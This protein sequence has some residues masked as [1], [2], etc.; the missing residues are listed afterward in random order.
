MRIRSVRLNLEKKRRILWTTTQLGGNSTLMYGICNGE[1][2]ARRYYQRGSAKAGTHPFLRRSLR[3]ERLGHA[4]VPVRV[5]EQQQQLPL[6][7]QSTCVLQVR[8][9]QRTRSVKWTLV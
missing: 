6:H 9:Y 2:R 3:V 5:A 7:A 4:A 1:R 8:S